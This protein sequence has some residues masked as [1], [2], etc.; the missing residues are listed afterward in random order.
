MRDKNRIKPILEKLE[1]YWLQNPDLRLGQ[2]IL[3]VIVPQ[4]SHSEVYY[5]EDE[6]FEEKLD[7]YISKNKTIS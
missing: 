4:S 5:L 2:I 7:E 6:K 3:N 1:N